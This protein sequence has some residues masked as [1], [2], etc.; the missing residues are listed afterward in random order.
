MQNCTDLPCSAWSS[1][2]FFFGVTSMRSFQNMHLITSSFKFKARKCL[3]TDL[4]VPLCL[5]V[6]C[7]QC[8]YRLHS[9]CSQRS[10]AVAFVLDCSQ[11]CRRLGG[12]EGRSWQRLFSDPTTSWKNPKCELVTL[13][14]DARTGRYMVCAYEWGAHLARTEAPLFSATPGPPPPA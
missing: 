6:K 9:Q 10:E 12:F 8:V 11:S 2:H 13:G 1:E 7:F 3:K 5:H 4:C 14:C